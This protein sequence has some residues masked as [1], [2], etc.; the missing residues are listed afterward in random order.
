MVLP[1][2]PAIILFDSAIQGSGRQKTDGPA[3]N[4][5]DSGD[6]PWRR[7]ETAERRAMG[8]VTQPIGIRARTQ[9]H[10]VVTLPIL[11]YSSVAAKI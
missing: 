9:R 1:R 3:Y 10:P 8:R 5:T 4:A 6:R 11:A 2:A 7:G